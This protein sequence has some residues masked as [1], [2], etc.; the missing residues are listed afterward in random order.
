[1]NALDEECK[2]ASH[3]SIQRC[4]VQ[5][6]PILTA[7]IS[8]SASML[9]LTSKT[10]VLLST[11]GPYSQLGT[12]VLWACL[13]TKTQ[14]ADINGKGPQKPPPSPPRA[15]QGQTPRSID[16]IANLLFYS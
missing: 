4:L 12:P 13:E 6:V 8:D 5:V 10:R 9:K 7:D 1:M 15:L 14:Y 2:E 3:T 16:N 11:A